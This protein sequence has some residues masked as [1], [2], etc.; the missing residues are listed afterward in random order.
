[1]ANMTDRKGRVEGVTV[2]QNPETA[3]LNQAELLPPVDQFLAEKAGVIRALAKKVV[4]DVIEIGR[5]LYEVRERPGHHGEFL[6]WLK[7]E[8]PDWS[9]RS[10]YNF[11]NV[12][13][14]FGTHSER[15]GNLE[16]PLAAFYK[17]AA[18]ST[19]QAVRAEVIERA[20]NGERLTTTTVK[21]MIGDARETLGA[22]HKTELDRNVQACGRKIA[23]LP[24]GSLPADHAAPAN[25]IKAVLRHLVGSLVITPEQFV[26]S[27]KQAASLAQ[28]Q[29]LATVV[30]DLEN[31]KAAVSWLQTLIKELEAIT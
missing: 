24:D 25:A 10:A 29:F 15:V 31:A 27:Q 19:P 28:R 2:A 9:P 5:H 17:L 4:R 6:P 8:F 30:D 23:G 18:P 21:K 20:A 3:M 11:M 16:L 14:V 7:R 13:V 12:F 1:M 22:A 26:G